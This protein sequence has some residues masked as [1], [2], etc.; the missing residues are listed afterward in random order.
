MLI[1][2]QPTFYP[3]EAE[4][5]GATPAQYGFVFGIANLSLFLF[6]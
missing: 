5:I 2:L 3:S 6:G 1:Y 4:E